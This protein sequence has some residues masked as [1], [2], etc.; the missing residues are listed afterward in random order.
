MKLVAQSAGEG[1]SNLAEYENVFG[2]RGELRVYLNSPGIPQAE[3]E[4][5]DT[6]IRNR[7]VVLIETVKQDAQVLVIGFRKGTLAAIT[8][9]LEVVVTP[10]IRVM[11]WQLF[12]ETAAVPLWAWLLG[13]VGLI[14]LARRKK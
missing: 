13:V 9:A 3:V 7:G 12:K 4:R 5:L 6:E 8:G 2:D 11:G 10:I 14:Y 1:I